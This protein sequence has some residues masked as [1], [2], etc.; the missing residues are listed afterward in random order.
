MQANW[1]AFIGE[2]VVAMDSHLMSYPINVSTEG[3]V[4]AKEETRNIVPDFPAAPLFGAQSN[5]AGG[6]GLPYSLTT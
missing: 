6:M 5:I 2:A 4:T 3:I 1:K